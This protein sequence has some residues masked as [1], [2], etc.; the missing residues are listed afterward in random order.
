MHKNIEAN[1]RSFETGK[2]K[3]GRIPAAGDFYEKQ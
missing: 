3:P 1:C 2:E